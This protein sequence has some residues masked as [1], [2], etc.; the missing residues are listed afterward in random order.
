MY[1]SLAASLSGSGIRYPEARSINLRLSLS[2][3]FGGRW[4]TASSLVVEASDW[5]RHAAFQSSLR[6]PVLG[7]AG[8]HR[9]SNETRDV[10]LRHRNLSQVRKSV[11]KHQ[12][13]QLELHMDKALGPR[14][15]E[16]SD[17][18]RGLGPVARR[19]LWSS[20]SITFDK[21]G[22]GTTRCK[23]CAWTSVSYVPDRSFPDSPLPL[24]RIEHFNRDWNDSV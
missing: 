13:C 10:S 11:P 22:P 8:S 12:N 20:S 23:P 1:S 4:P 3:P 24:V 5:G 19:F 2:D 17:S 9:S 14:F 16:H 6:L 18:N 15:A 21:V 7:R